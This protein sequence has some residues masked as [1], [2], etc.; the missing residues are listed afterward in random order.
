MLYFVYIFLFCIKN[1][2]LYD[3]D[4][5]FSLPMNAFRKLLELLDNKISL[6]LEM[7][8]LIPKTGIIHEIE[9]CECSEG[10]KLSFFLL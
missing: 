7:S 5:L 1:V 6:F 2:I 9:T 8:L 3:K 4:E 10:T